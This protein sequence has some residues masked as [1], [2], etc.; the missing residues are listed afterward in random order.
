[1]SSTLAGTID[2]SWRRVLESEF[3]KPY[4][5][6][7]QEFLGEEKQAGK[8]IYPPDGQIFN[9]FN[10]TPFDK[11]KVVILGQDPYHGAGQAHGLCFS[12]LPG[13][14]VPPSLRNIYKELHS[15]LGIEP[16]HHGC[17]QP[18]AEQGVLL[19]N[20]T[21]TVED[22]KA[23]AHQ[24]RG[25]EVFTDAVIHALAEQREGLVFILW[26]SHAQ[27][28]GAFI[29][30]RRH[31]VLRAPHPSPLSAHRGFFGTK[32]FSRA[33][34]WLQERGEEPIRWAL[35]PADSLRRVAVEV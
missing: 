35:P 12:V 1:M 7:L 6:Q 17:L 10:S 15:D 9:A 2:P 16:A 18:W 11:V 30:E 3:R 32:P 19:L 8:Q 26:G 13:V 28:K 21:L 5:G 22:S 14:R 27:K 25:W 33:N 20:A 4:M 24:G 34:Q 29:D 31:L 23:G